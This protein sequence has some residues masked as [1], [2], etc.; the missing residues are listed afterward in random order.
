[1]KKLTRIIPVLLLVI[2]F[3]LSG[4]AAFAASLTVEVKQGN[5]KGAGHKVTCGLLAKNCILPLTINA[6]GTPQQLKIHVTY[7]SGNVVLMFQTS[8]GYYYAS[9]AGA[10]SGFYNTL[11]M[12]PVSGPANYNITLVKPL[13]QNHFVPPRL[14]IPQPSVASLGITVTLGP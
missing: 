6:G 11:W 14:S 2:F 3:A 8:N 1:M 10:K 13:V 5:S 4:S 9:D 12:K 7:L